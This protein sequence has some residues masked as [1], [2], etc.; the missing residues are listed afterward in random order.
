ME[1]N[2]RSNEGRSSV[3][4]VRQDGQATT[5]RK[6]LFLGERFTLDHRFSYPMIVLPDIKGG[7]FVPCGE[8]SSPKGRPR[9]YYAYLSVG[10]T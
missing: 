4:V 3:E 9:Y 6:L 7:L 2:A 8:A 10:V 1:G 5:W